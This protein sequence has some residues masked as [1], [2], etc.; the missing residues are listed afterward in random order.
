MK[1][2]E[3]FDPD[4]MRALRERIRGQMMI[5]YIAARYGCGTEVAGEADRPKPN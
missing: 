3:P 2:L 4:D 1:P 5:A